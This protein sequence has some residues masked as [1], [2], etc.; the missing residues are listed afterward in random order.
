MSTTILFGNGINRISPN[1]IS[2][3]D[4]L[5]QIK[6]Q[7]PFN[8]SNLPNTM[9]Y[10]KIYL[11]SKSKKDELTIKQD[12]AKALALQEHNEIYNDLIN[13]GFDNYLTT[14]YDYAFQKAISAKPT[15]NSTEDIYSLRRHRTYITNK[16]SIKLWHIHGEID[17]PKS[18][19]LGL[20]HY[21]GSI[22]K[23]DSYVKGT[24]TTKKYGNPI[25]VNSMN[26]KLQ[27]RNFCNTS[28]VDLFFSGNVHIVA[29]SL[30]FSETD[31]WWVLN[32]RARLNLQRPINNSI[33]FHTNSTEKS[34]LD[35]LESFNVQVLNYTVIDG[36][37][38]KMYKSILEKIRNL[39]HPTHPDKRIV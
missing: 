21:C 20:D 22:S 16:G 8:H 39:A 19:M 5:N 2:W 33:Y 10:E 27:N 7:P 3:S 35:L 26:E 34:K 1:A 28:W 11:G 15:L 6:E 13:L 17:H 25:S 36:D 24:Y 32:R 31:L 38:F 30:D 23:L 18:I 12:I 9:V 14:N 29:L 37:Y 4:L